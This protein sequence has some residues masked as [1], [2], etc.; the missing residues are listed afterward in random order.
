[1]KNMKRWIIILAAFVIAVGASTRLGSFKLKA[2][3]G[4]GTAADLQI[5]EVY[6]EPVIEVELPPMEEELPE[7]DFVD[8][9][10]IEEELPVEEISTALSACILIIE[11]AVRR[12]KCSRR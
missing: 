10:P 6:E 2:S 3:D 7:E 8:E 4:D 12:A 9:A 1:M 5:E 11:V